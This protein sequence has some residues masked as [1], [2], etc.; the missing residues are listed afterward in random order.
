MMHLA[1]M[2]ILIAIIGFVAWGAVLSL[3]FLFR[4]GMRDSHTV[5]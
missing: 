3:V 5:E 4:D 2:T 1:T